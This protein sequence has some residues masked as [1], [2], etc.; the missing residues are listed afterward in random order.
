MDA[1]KKDD[2]L[3]R[4]VRVAKRLPTSRTESFCEALEDGSVNRAADVLPDMQ[5]RVEAR[6]LVEAWQ[7]AGIS[8]IGQLT[9]A[10]RAAAATDDDW[11]DSQ[12]LELVWTGPS[13]SG[14]VFR[15]TDQALLE[16][17]D[18]CGKDLWIVSFV[19]YKIDA[20]NRALQAAV[21]RGVSINLVLESKRESGGRI[22]FDGID[23]L[24]SRIRRKSRVF[25]WPEDKRPE[26]DDGMRGALHA[27]C[28]VADSHKLLISS[29]NL[30]D[31]AMRLNIELGVMVTG[32]PL[33]GRVSANLYAM[34]SSST[35][36]EI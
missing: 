22:G 15:R 19:A 10:L 11:R 5:S 12:R 34:V 2:L 7:A 18:F 33:P 25:V 30:T 13:D 24:D 28:A 35:L 21:D 32:G 1:A 27:K 16:L 23:A 31:A 6:H 4:I 26:S 3:A 8:D 20:I 9:W 14:E 17:I 29:A 36:V